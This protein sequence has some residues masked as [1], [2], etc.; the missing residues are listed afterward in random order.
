[1]EQEGGLLART[2]GNKKH[3]RS[4]QL[5]LARDNISP[6]KKKEKSRKQ[7]MESESWLESWYPKTTSSHVDCCKSWSPPSARQGPREQLPEHLCSCI[8]TVHTMQLYLIVHFKVVVLRRDASAGRRRYSCF[9]HVA[10]Q[11]R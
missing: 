9:V 2:M 10:L 6:F 8:H 7:T 11:V 5:P 3:V 1:M 4:E